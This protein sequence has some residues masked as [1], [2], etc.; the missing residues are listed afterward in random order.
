MKRDA[1]SHKIYIQILKKM[2]PQ[3]RVE[4]SLELSQMADELA[5]EGLKKRYPELSSDQIHAMFIEQKI[6]CHNRNY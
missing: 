2:T 1:K 4:K 3:Q 6:Q 5:K